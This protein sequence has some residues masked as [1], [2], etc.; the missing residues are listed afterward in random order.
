M[1]AIHKPAFINRAIG[2]GRAAGSGDLAQ[3]P[4]AVIRAAIG[5]SDAPAPLWLAFHKRAFINRPIGIARRSLAFDLAVHPGTRILI[6]V[7]QFVTAR[8][9]LQTIGK[10]AGVDRSILVLFGYHLARRLCWCGPRQS[11]NH[12]NNPQNQNM[13]HF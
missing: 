1:F 2:I 12:R 9:I 7:G 4:V 11:Q 8:A 3:G 10:G 5:V 13:P 6:S